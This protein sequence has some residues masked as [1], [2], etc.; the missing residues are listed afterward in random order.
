MKQINLQ[1]TGVL[2]ESTYFRYAK[3]EFFSARLGIDF[4][5]VC[6]PLQLTNM[7]LKNNIKW[8]LSNV[9]CS[10][11]DQSIYRHIHCISCHFGSAMWR[12]FI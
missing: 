11:I 8:N 2:D 3:P 9:D 7:L 10:E 1:A 6:C 4:V 5:Q 12:I